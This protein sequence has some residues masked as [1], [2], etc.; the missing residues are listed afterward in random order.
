MASAAWQ[1]DAQAKRYRAT[2]TGRFIPRATID[3][4]RNDYAE[5][6]AGGMRDLA[7]RLA[8]RQVTLQEWEAGMRQEIRL[9][10][11][12][13][14]A[15]GRGGR[16]AMTPADWGHVGVL[17]KG[18]YG[19]LRGFAEEIGRGSLTAA[20]IEARAALYAG[21]S[22]QAHAQGIAAAHGFK[23]PRHPG[24]GSTECMANCRCHLR[25]EEDTDRWRVYWIVDD[26][27]AH[28]RDCPGIAI[29]W[30]PLTIFKAGA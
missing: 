13:Q 21:S 8:G 4:L 18:Q 26:G 10:M 30:N 7:V 15:F 3:R 24:D 22:V 14:Y 19:Y 27:A 16:G 29:D 5:A 17:C 1:F 25:I 9:A 2:A 12:G 20:Q 6:R 28:C 23:L 11:G